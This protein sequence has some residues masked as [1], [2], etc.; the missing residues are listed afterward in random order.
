MRKKSY[1]LYEL[2]CAGDVRVSLVFD[3]DECVLWP[4]GLRSS[5]GYGAI[6]VGGKHHQAH[7]LI[8][9]IVNKCCILP[10][11]KVRHTCDNPPCVN[12]RHLILGTQADNMADCARRGRLGWSRLK[13]RRH[14]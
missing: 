12:A 9:E 13:R 2:L 7:R 11:W 1:G 8:Y 6:G 4:G 3:T 14:L 10:G 5:G